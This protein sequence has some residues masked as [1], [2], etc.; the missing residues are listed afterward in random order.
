MTLASIDWC[1]RRRSIFEGIRRI[2]IKVIFRNIEFISEVFKN[3][4]EAFDP[5][6]ILIEGDESVVILVNFIKY[7]VE[8][9]FFEFREGSEGEAVA[10][11]DDELISVQSF[12]AN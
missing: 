2:Q 11:N 4:Q 12:L 3:S 5:I 9:R 6:E 10:E 1:G 8:D 7:F